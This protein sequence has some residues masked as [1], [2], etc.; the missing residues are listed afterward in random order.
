MTLTP[1]VPNHPKFRF[2]KGFSFIELFVAIAVVTI[3]AAI[4]TLSYRSF[5]TKKDMSNGQQYLAELQQKQELFYQNQRRYSNNITE[6]GLPARPVGSETSFIDVKLFVV[7]REEV[8]HAYYTAILDPVNA[9]N[10]PIAVSEGGERYYEYTSECYQKAGV[11]TSKN[12]ILPTAMSF[13]DR[14][15]AVA[16]CRFSAGDIR[17]DENTKVAKSL[18]NINATANKATN[19][20]DALLAVF[21]QLPVGA[22]PSNYADVQEGISLKTPE[23]SACN[24]EAQNKKIT[25]GVYLPITVGDTVQTCSCG[26][27]SVSMQPSATIPGGVECISYTGCGDDSGTFLQKRSNASCTVVQRCDNASNTILGATDGNVKTDVIYANPDGN[28]ENGYQVWCSAKGILA[29]NFQDPT[30]STCYG[31]KCNANGGIYVDETV[32][33]A[34]YSVSFNCQATTTSAYPSSSQTYTDDNGDTYRI[35]C[36]V[37]TTMNVDTTNVQDSTCTQYSCSGGKVGSGF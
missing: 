10:P 2:S 33:L 30:K 37:G 35:S 25:A 18:K 32:N 8:G 11:G 3:L 22:T 14:F 28:G 26:S 23:V 16:N 19:P 6:L 27:G 12:D 36:P 13:Y 9:D 31:A 21:Q 24:Y 15:A 34:Q 5:A 1:P 17:W 20:A 4:T 29:V 7:S